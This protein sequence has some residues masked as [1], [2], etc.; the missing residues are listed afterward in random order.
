L[1]ESACES[2]FINASSNDSANGPRLGM[3]MP[4][5]SNRHR[6]VAHKLA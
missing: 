3:T 5:G 2:G 6:S 4:Q 1:R